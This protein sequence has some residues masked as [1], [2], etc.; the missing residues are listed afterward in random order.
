MYLEKTVSRC[1]YIRP[2]RIF[3]M[4]ACQPLGSWYVPF[5]WIG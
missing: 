2:I 1:S 4:V 3:G 5:N